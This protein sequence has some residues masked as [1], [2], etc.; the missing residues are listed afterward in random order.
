[1]NKIIKNFKNI[2]YGPAPEDDT[3]VIN[4]INKISSPN[5]NYING[6]WNTS[7]RSKKI[8]V[9]NPSTNKKLFNLTISTK[10]D[11]DLAVNSAR[12]AQKKWSSIS[13]FQRSKYLYALAR[14]IQKHSRFL[15]V[16]ESIDNG[17]PI[18]E[19]RD[20]DIPLVARHFYYHAG[21]AKNSTDNNH[22]PID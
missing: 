11:V 8:K 1:M 16:L 5:K 20:I 12:K 2:K 15:A 17:K 13:S 22:K 9:I 4:W 14:L 7:K 6:K 21:W 3:E 18:R 19:T 10:K